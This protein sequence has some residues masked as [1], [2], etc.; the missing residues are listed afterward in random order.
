MSL[1]NDP[2][3]LGETDSSEVEDVEVILSSLQKICA[4][5]EKLTDSSYRRF[6]TISKRAKQEATPLRNQKLQ[7]KPAASKWLRSRT[8]PARPTFREFFELFLQEHAKEHRV[9]IS[10]RSILLNNDA[11]HLF[12]VDIG[13]SLTFYELMRKL[14]LLFD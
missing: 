7:P 2:L 4:N 1:S 8:L 11:C 6:K 5:M 13:T 10:N 3:L 9:Y 14:P 12:Q